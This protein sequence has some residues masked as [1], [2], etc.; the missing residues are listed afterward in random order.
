MG[1]F[2]L[3]LCQLALT[4]LIEGTIIALWLKSKEATID[5]LYVN[6][7]TNPPLNLT[8]LLLSGKGWSLAMMW[9]ILIVLE[10]SVVF[11]EA[12][13]YKSMLGHGFKQ[14]LWLSFVLNLTSFAMGNLIGMAGYWHLQV[15]MM[16]V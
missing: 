16:N 7:L 12:I 2:L 8:L 15:W 9:V 10:T 4:V 1:P 5:S 14:A 6:L 3:I 13:A 11:I